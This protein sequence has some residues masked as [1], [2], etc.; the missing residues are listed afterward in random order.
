VTGSRWGASGAAEHVAER[1]L[2]AAHFHNAEIGGLLGLLFH[3]DHDLRW[4]VAA[5][6]S[7]HREHAGVAP[8][9]RAIPDVSLENL[10]HSSPELAIAS[11]LLV[12]DLCTRCQS[13]AESLNGRGITLTEP[14]VSD[15]MNRNNIT[16]S[17]E[18][19][20]H[21]SA[22]A[23]QAKADYWLR[24]HRLILNMVKKTRL[25]FVLIH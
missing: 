12:V 17:V 3:E 6:Y 23:G 21:T 8:A 4:F 25:E 18:T 16:F 9:A 10:P 5:G 19:G 1:S 2:A 11:N 24:G 20:T 13:K 15:S 22:I 7:K 14:D